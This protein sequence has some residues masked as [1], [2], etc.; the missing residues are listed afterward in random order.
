MD[1]IL[2][3]SIKIAS[4]IFLLFFVMGGIVSLRY[5]ININFF[6]SGISIVDSLFFLAASIMFFVNYGGLSFLAMLLGLLILFIMRPLLNSML[7]RWGP[8][9][10]RCITPIHSS[11]SAGI[12]AGLITIIALVFFYIKDETTFEMLLFSSI[13]CF[14]ILL[15]LHT[16]KNHNPPLINIRIFNN[17]NPHERNPR[18][19]KIALLSSLMLIP[20]ISGG[21]L[22]ASR[23]TISSM[24]IA[25][26][27]ADVYIDKQLLPMFNDIKFEEHND[28]IEIKDVNVLWNGVGNRTL[29]EVNVENH[30]RKKIVDSSKITFSYK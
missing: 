17:G 30:T 23:M 25:I 19:A 13:L 28:V 5:C 26:K 9:D 2:E 27:H 24:G 3:R 20:L 21:F 1:R 7:S 18:I 14:P 22:V 29:I 10:S 15:I 16:S 4:L 11:I 6:P 8:N 12:P